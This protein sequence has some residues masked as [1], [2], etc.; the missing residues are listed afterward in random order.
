MSD[1][2]SYDRFS[3]TLPSALNEWLH[4]FIME[5]KNAGGYKLPRT[6]I[7]RAFIRAIRESNLN[8]DLSNIKD[9][10]K[11]GISPLL[12]LPLVENAFKHSHDLNT[13]IEIYVS[14][15]N[16]IF[17]FTISNNLTENLD[18]ELLQKDGI[19]L[20]N[21]KR[22]LAILYEDY[23]FEAVKKDLTFEV[24]LTIHLNSLIDA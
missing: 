3:L 6:L 18:S 11:K 1:K 23:S 16:D 10:E 15:H 24:K 22:Q 19:G 17:N 21:I 20:S 12:L 8:I 13:H 2:S 14:L 5:I 4:Q 7:I 9:D